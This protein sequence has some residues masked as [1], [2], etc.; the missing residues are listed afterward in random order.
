MKLVIIVNIQE[1]RIVRTAEREERAMDLI[2]QYGNETAKSK[3]NILPESDADSDPGIYS[4]V[5]SSSLTT[6]W[7][8]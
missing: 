8:Y 6:G 5:G 7:E 3:Y 2:A 1:S 4:E